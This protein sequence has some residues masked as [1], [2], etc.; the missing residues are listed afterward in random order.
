MKILTI[1]ILIIFTILLACSKQ[2]EVVKLEVGTPEYQFAKE[3]SQK[4]PALDPDS[5]KIMVQTKKFKISTGEVIQAM[6]TNLGKRVEQL[7]KMNAERLEGIIRDNAKGIAEKKLLLRTAMD[8]GITVSQE[9]ID[10]V[11]NVQFSHVGG[12]ERYL[13]M[14]ARNNVSFE[15]VKDDTRNSLL[16]QHYFEDVV[17][18]QIEI[19][20][21]DIQNEFD[22]NYSGDR[23]A[24]V[25]HILLMT[26]G[27][28]DS[29]K[30]N[31]REKM[32]GILARAKAGEDF[33][34]L[35]KQYSEDPGSKDR[36]GLYVNFE[37][38]DMVKPFEDA[39]FSVPIGGL[40]DIVETRY[41]Y[42]ILKIVDREKNTQTLDELR[43]EI[44]DKIREPKKQQVYQAHLEQ[45]KE[46]AGFEVLEL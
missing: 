36:G 20:E 25:R 14:L 38:G 23:K 43:S 16:I 9:E 8:E 1:L 39:A 21:E 18:D 37:K 32:E 17:A 27:K 12:K 42:H 6:Q 2:E 4:I 40:S 41:G 7:T 29:E 10:S 15:F 19:G 22:K 45:L 31:I 33:A 30:K 28:S 44:I 26:Q 46:N 13:E 11:L 5:N 35:A 34:E 3:L 24:T